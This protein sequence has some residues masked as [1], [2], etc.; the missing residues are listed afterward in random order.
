[1]RTRFTPLCLGIALAFPFAAAAAA[2][3]GDDQIAASFERMLNHVPTATAPA[4][5]TARDDDP[6]HIHLAAVLWERHPGLC[7][8]VRTDVATAALGTVH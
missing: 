8:A 7:G 1:M 3:A 2:P 5:P 6:L 4:A